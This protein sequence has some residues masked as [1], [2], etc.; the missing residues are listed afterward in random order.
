MNFLSNIKFVHLTDCSIWA[1]IRFL[2]GTQGET[3]RD[4]K[5]AGV[6]VRKG[7]KLQNE[8]GQL[9]LMSEPIKLRREARE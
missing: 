1:G 3:G 8:W 2:N 4:S 5:N 9:L 6:P 7:R